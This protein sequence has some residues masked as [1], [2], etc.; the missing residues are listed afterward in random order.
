MDEGD[1]CASTQVLKLI[2]LL[3]F[4]SS[5]QMQ[6]SEPGFHVAEASVANTKLLG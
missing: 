2:Q 4:L 1:V 6:R 3:L 5:S